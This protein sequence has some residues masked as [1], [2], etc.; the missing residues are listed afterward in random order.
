MAKVYL[1][2]ND[3]LLEVQDVI[4]AA[5]SANIND[6]SVTVT[7]YSGES[8]SEVSGQSWPLTLAY[9][10]GSSGLYRATL[11][12]TLVVDVGDKIRAEIA[13]SGG[14]NLKGFFEATILVRKRKV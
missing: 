2:A 11:V 7:C 10:S 6:A 14:V 5:T 9:V 3:N 8:S 12:D 13:V 4:N 1:Y